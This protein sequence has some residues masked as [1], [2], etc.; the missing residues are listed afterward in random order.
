M[1]QRAPSHDCIVDRE[2]FAQAKAEKVLSRRARFQV[3]R[4]QDGR[5]K[6]SD[7]AAPRTKLSCTL[8]AAAAVA[9]PSIG[10]FFTTARMRSDESFLEAVD[11]EGLAFLE[12][13]TRS[14]SW[15][16]APDYWLCDVVRVLDAIDEE[17][18]RGES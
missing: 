16:A 5:W 13:E 1:P 12:C 10:S 7:A 17:K 15:K 2:A 3:R 6:I 11:G 4:H 14:L 9:R 18:T 8:R